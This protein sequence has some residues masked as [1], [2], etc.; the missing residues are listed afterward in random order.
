MCE[1]TYTYRPLFRLPS[2]GRI[3][4]IYVQGNASRAAVSGDGFPTARWDG[5]VS[6][7]TAPF[8]LSVVLILERACWP[9]LECCLPTY[10]PRWE[11]LL[12]WNIAGVGIQVAQSGSLAGLGKCGLK[13]ITNRRPPVISSHRF[14]P[15][16][17]RSAA[18]SLSPR[19]SLSSPEGTR[20]SRSL[21]RLP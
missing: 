10:L 5:M 2:T 1:V 8:V 4:V 18:P 12:F 19:L 6:S 3:K 20:R 16:S 7:I 21:I 11:Y 13:Y 14:T 17:L 9:W 15:H